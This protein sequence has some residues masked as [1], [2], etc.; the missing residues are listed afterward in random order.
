MDRVKEL[1]KK[2]ESLGN[3]QFSFA[4]IIDTVRMNVLMDT[5]AM[6]FVAFAALLVAGLG[7]TNT[8]INAW[9]GPQ[10]EFIAS[11]RDLA[12]SATKE[13]FA[14]FDLELSVDVL[15]KLQDGIGR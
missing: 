7:F 10:T 5:F 11:P 1:A 12:A 9:E 8:M 13:F 3:S 2:V 6:V 4:E 14:R 15:K